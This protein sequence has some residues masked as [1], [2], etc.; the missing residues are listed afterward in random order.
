MFGEEYKLWSSSLWSFQQS[1]V[2]SSPFG[3]NILLRTLLS[4]T[5]SLC[6]SLNVRAKFSHPYRTTGNIIVLYILK[7][8]ATLTQVFR[9]FPRSF[10]PSAREAPYIRPPQSRSKS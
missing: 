7:T 6:S 5:L 2:T 4:N 1:A 8:P 9:D 10:K 3:P